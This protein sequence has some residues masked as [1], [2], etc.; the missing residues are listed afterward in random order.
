VNI[1]SLQNFVRYV[2]EVACVFTVGRSKAVV[3]AIQQEGNMLDQL[4][5]KKKNKQNLLFNSKNELK[6]KTQN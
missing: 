1:V 6:T 5:K 4:K 3:D 2:E